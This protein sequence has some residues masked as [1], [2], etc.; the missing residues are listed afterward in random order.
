MPVQGRT[1]T[2]RAWSEYIT[3]LRKAAETDYNCWLV[4]LHGMPDWLLRVPLIE[5]LARIPVEVEYASEFRYR[6][7]DNNSPK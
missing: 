3:K 1:K 2:W 7:P 6:N 4:V 5:D